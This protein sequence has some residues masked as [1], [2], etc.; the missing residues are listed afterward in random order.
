MWLAVTLGDGMETSG[1][2]NRVAT[3]DYL[4]FNFSQ[5]VDAQPL[6]P[7][8]RHQLN[9]QIKSAATALRQEPQQ[10]WRHVHASLGVEGI[11]DI[12]RD[13]YQVAQ[14]AVEEYLD[15][16]KEYAAC[17]KLVGQILRVAADKGI[18][19]PM[20]SFCLGAF[21][22]DRLKELGREDL[23]QVYAFVESH[24][25]ND[26]ELVNE[27]A[28]TLQHCLQINSVRLVVA[29]A[30]FGGCVAGGFFF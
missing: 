16:A 3:R 21:G 4:E 28:A 15:G 19:E 9:N 24:T 27:Q 2:G 20:E 5:Q 18:Q 6:V 26:K 13:Q 25:A 7:A 10:I 29:A 1:N 22:M 23:A 30:F 14:Q 8:Q 17:Q 12:T 11:G